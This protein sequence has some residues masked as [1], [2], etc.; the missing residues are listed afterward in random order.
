MLRM[1]LVAGLTVTLAS[2]AAQASTS[3]LLGFGTLPSSQGFTYTPIGS[4]AAALEA[5]IFAISGGVLTQNSI[6]QANGT[7][8]GS[9][10]YVIPGII[11]ASE[12]SELHVTARCLQVQGTATYPA[13]QM[14]FV[15]GI[16][17]GSAQF[18]ISLTPTAV[19][20]LGPSGPVAVA[21]SYDNTQFHD[22]TLHF[23]PPATFR[24]YRDGGLLHTGTGGSPF[25]SN[26]LFFGDGTG[27]ANA[28]AEIRSLQFL[29][30]GA[31]ATD[32][33]TWGGVKELFR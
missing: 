32:P 13:G 5:S 31:V 6:G 28:L 14:G 8:G 30:G 7:A 1:K 24:I 11:A 4:H 22:W 29:Q 2:A 16:N 25:A 18:A 3:V 15:F 23:D 19:Y 17:T 12:T 21:G 33:A 10:L 9:I 20:T 27:G 26:R